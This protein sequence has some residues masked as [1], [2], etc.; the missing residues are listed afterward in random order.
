MFLIIVGSVIACV[1]ATS[2]GVFLYRRS[3][4]GKKVAVLH[5]KCANCRRRL[6][7]RSTQRGHPGRCPQCKTILKFPLVS[8]EERK[9]QMKRP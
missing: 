4:R 2:G 9:A 5:F 8:D 7:Y 3:Q 1:A 6:A